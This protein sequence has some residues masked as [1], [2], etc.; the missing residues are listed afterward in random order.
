M[1]YAVFE[2]EKPAI[3]S[4]SEDWSNNEFES[5]EDAEDYCINWLG[6]FIGPN[7]KGILKLN[8]K[9]FFYSGCYVEI[10]GIE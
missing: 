6:H 10:K 5:F 1:R 4:N 9:Y 3:L 8:E 7:G 2:N